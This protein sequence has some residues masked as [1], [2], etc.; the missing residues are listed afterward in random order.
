MRAFLIH[1]AFGNPQENWFPWLT[2]ELENKGYEVVAPH[3]PT[4]ENQSLES[5]MKVWSEYEKLVDERTIFIGHSLG[6]AFILNILKRVQGKVKSCFFVSGFVGLLG[7]EKF[8]SINKTF[9]EK[10]FDWEELKEHCER[11]VLFH[12]DNDPYVS[13]EKAEELTS[14]VDGK[15][16]V[17]KNGGHLNS[18]AGFTELSQLLENIN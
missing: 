10:T 17:I 11:F 12:G 2:K 1:G 7:N 9:V 15:L 18:A 6:S 16:H 4:P 14:M 13:V 5:W 8:D 3:F